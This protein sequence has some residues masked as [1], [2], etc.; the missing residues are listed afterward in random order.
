MLPKRSRLTVAAFNQFFKRG[1]R[2]HGTYCTLVYTPHPQFR[3]AVVVGKK[4]YRRAVDRN[5]LRRQLYPVLA[6]YAE[7]T[8]AVGVYQCLVKPAAAQVPVALVREELASLL[9]AT[10]K[11][12]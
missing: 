9:A 3:G 2:S 7:R 10:A 8:G 5:R 1:Q 12:R 4:V 6:T 11:A